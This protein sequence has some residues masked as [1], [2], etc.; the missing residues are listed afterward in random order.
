[1]TS[2]CQCD[3][4]GSHV[5][6]M[7][8]FSGLHEADELS[9]HTALPHLG[10][11]P[12][13]S[14]LQDIRDFL[15]S[16]MGSS[17]KAVASFQRSVPSAT[18]FLQAGRRPILGLAAAGASELLGAAPRSC[19]SG[20]GASSSCRTVCLLPAPGRN[21]HEDFLFGNQLPDD[22]LTPRQSMMAGWFSAAKLTLRGDPNDERDE[23][24]DTKG[25]SRAVPRSL[26]FFSAVDVATA[27]VVFATRNYVCDA[28]LRSWLLGG[29]MLGG[30]MDLLIKGIAWFLKPRYKYYKFTIVSCR[31]DADTAFDVKE[32]N[33]SDE[34]DRK[35]YYRNPGD[36]T[37]PME[38]RR[39]NELML[40][41]PYPKMIS[42][43]RITTGEKDAK[44]DPVAWRLTASNNGRTWRLI[45]KVED[46]R[47]PYNRSAESD[48]FSD[49]NS[50]NEDASFRQ[51]FL[52]ELIASGAALAWL[53]LGS[54]WV[55]GSSE[56][57]IDSAPELWYY[58]FLMAV[59]TWSCIGTVTIGLIVS[60]VA[61][62]VLG[63]KSP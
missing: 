63:V 57:C 27:I 54:A 49:L 62:I 42:G 29:I 60:A 6:A 11:N 56:T 5:G 34:F 51:A 59:L 26:V 28:P 4:R 40:E 48:F 12:R 38:T 13:Q 23:E 2:A 47:L 61:M 44:S 39:G 3:P 8:L 19:R 35:L 9:V 25:W 24:T 18:A 32:I 10:I 46:G 22:A 21:T 7:V 31:N 53:T 15:Q 50:L 36:P 16:H 14:P 33:L 20:R 55:A 17:D 45:H 1:L 41:F 37:P 58:S 52:A 43:Y 30:P